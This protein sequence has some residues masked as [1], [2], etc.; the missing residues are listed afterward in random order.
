VTS[1]VPLAR[2][3]RHHSAAPPLPWVTRVAEQLVRGER[4]GLAER[5][6]DE[7]RAVLE[8]ALEL[9]PKHRRRGT[10]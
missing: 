3:K 9:V 2:R 4:I 6:H 8:A 5:D 7:Q 10:A 1:D